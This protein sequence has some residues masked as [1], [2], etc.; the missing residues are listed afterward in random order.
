MIK[1]LQ[2]WWIFGNS[3]YEKL[4][5]FFIEK[6]NYSVCQVLNEW[7]EKKING[8]IKKYDAMVIVKTLKVYVFL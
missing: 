1:Q 7:T 8:R 6:K 3:T 4:I 2:Y 5:V